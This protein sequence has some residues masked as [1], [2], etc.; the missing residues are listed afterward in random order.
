MADMPTAVSDG[1]YLPA[2]IALRD[3][4]ADRLERAGSR[5]VAAIAKQ[6]GDVMRE[7]EQLSVPEESDGVDEVARRREERRA[8]AQAS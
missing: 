2:L 8:K 1:K 7:I 6:L 5:D 3:F 4:L